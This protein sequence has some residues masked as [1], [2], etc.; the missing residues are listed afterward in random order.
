MR[1]PKPPLSS[2]AL[3]CKNCKCLIFS[4][5]NHDWRA[6]LCFSDSEDTKGCYI[7]GGFSYCR[8]GGFNGNYEEATVVFKK[9]VSI[10]TLY[11]DWNKGKDRLGLIK[12]GQKLPKEI[13]EI[14][15]AKKVK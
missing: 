8:V 2:I 12:F 14:I 4:R 1:I 5:A 9:D 15:W 11:N 6:C 3:F 13:A 7:D 10:T